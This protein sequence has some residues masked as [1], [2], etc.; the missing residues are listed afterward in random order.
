MAIKSVDDLN[1]SG[2]RVFVRVDFNVP[3]DD[4]QVT[5]DTR[6]VAALPTIKNLKERGA[7]IILASHLGR[8]G[9]AGPEPEFSLQ[10]AAA[11]LAELLECDVKFIDD[12]VGDGPKKAVSDLNDG[13]ILVLENLRFHKGEKKNDPDFSRKLAE[14][15]EVYVNDAFGTSH[16]AHASVVGIPALVEEK[17]AGYLMFKEWEYFNKLLERPVKPFWAVLGGA[18]VSDKVGVVENLLK[19]VD[20]IVIG[21][22]MANTF[23]ASQGKKLGKS[24]IEEDKLQIAKE[25]LEKAEL[26]SIRILLPDDHIAAA[27]LDSDGSTA[28]A[29]TNA[30]FPQDLMALDI[31]PKTVEKFKNALREAKTVFWN[32]PMGVFEKDAFANGTIE[33]AKMIAESNAVS[34]VGGG[35]SVAAAAKAGVSGKIN[36]ISTGGGASL[37]FM[38]GKKLPG[39]TA[40]Q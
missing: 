35:D 13:D 23:L 34:V 32:G 10:P 2:R 21:G 8:P 19:L 26:R 30:D 9:G 25:T 29:A 28:K 17:G 1:V 4:G 22:A 24:K 36:H 37:E 12:C 11:R 6:I 39:F 38:E 15:C 40:L 20:G 18:K 33:I 5:D 7:K 16:R 3:I 14:L 27:G 31:G